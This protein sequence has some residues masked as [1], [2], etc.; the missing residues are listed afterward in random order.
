MFY[1]SKKYNQKLP[2]TH[3]KNTASFS[4]LSELNMLDMFEK[5]WPGYQ[6]TCIHQIIRVMRLRPGRFFQNHI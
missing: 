1:D 2:T 5:S 4:Q 3:P 6:I